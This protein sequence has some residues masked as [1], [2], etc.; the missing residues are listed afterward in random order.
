MVDGRRA[1][2]GEEKA[3]GVHAVATPGRR[4][5][6]DRHPG[7]GIVGGD[8]GRRARQPEP[9]DENVDVG[10]CGEGH[11]GAPDM[12]RSGSEPSQPSAAERTIA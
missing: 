6:D 4:P 1:V 7:P 12:I 3:A 11:A 2:D 5:F 10:L 9:D 8:R